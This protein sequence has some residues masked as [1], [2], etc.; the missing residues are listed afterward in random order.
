MK[1]FIDYSLIINAYF[2]IIKYELRNL[3]KKVNIYKSFMKHFVY[4]LWSVYIKESSI[5]TNHHSSQ[6]RLVRIA[7]ARTAS[8]VGRWTPGRRWT[9]CWDILPWWTETT[10]ARASCTSRVWSSTWRGVERNAP[11][12]RFRPP[13]IYA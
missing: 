5:N 1:C 4:V 12:L 9:P 10:A 7:R 11:S 13:K 6:R 3:W 8:C 2:N